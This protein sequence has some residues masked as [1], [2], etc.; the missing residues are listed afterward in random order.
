MLSVCVFLALVILHTK[1]M[2]CIISPS[3]ACLSVPYFSTLFY[4]RHDFRK[5]KSCWKQNAC[6]AFLY[7]SC[8]KKF[9]VKKNSERYCHTFTHVVAKSVLFSCLLQRN[10]NFLDRFSKNI[11]YTKFNENQLSGSRTVPCGRTDG[12]TH[13]QTGM[14]KLTVVLRNFV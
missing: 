7:N 11:D 1:R 12:Q 8:Q 5:K 13:W 4:K 10:S 9:P 3:V 14:T 2:H 6:F